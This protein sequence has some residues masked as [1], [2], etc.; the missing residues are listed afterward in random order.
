VKKLIIT[1][2]SKKSE[3]R[4]RSGKL[5]LNEVGDRPSPRESP[6][7]ISHDKILYWLQGDPVRDRQTLMAK[8]L[9]L[10]YDGS[11]LKAIADGTVARRW[12]AT[13]GKLDLI[14]TMPKF[15]KRATQTWKKFGALPD[16]C[17]YTLGSLITAEKNVDPSILDKIKYAYGEL[18]LIG[19]ELKDRVEKEFSEPEKDKKELDEAVDFREKST[20]SKIAWGENRIKIKGSCVGRGGFYI[21]GG[22]LKGSSGCLDVG[23]NMPDFAEWWG[24]NTVG[25]RRN[26]LLRV[27]YSGVFRTGNP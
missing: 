10:L 20:T 24:V 6:G 3:K 7:A 22:E 1:I 9:Y 26:I 15:I 2:G 4:L 19:K 25:R 16:K 5:T 12:P 17:T 8:E 18:R 27:D 11:Y 23:K 13:T 21:H 14:A